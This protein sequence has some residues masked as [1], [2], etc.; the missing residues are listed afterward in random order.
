MKKRKI[1]S[2]F[3]SVP[4]QKES[5]NI[6]VPAAFITSRDAGMNTGTWTLLIILDQRA[7]PHAVPRHAHVA[8]FAGLTLEQSDYE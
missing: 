7:P 3:H 5:V 1:Y 4:S 2:V 8:V 6:N